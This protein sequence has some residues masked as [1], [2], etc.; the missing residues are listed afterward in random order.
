MKQQRKLDA[1]THRTEQWST[2]NRKL[3]ELRKQLEDLRL[4]LVAVRNYDA[5]MQDARNRLAH[6]NAQIVTLNRQ[7]SNENAAREERAQQR[8]TLQQRLEAECVQHA[9]A[10]KAVNEIEAALNVAVA[11]C[12][13][14]PIVDAS[15][16]NKCPIC[17]QALNEEHLKAII[18]ECTRREAEKERLQQEL[19][20][21]ISKKQTHEDA[22]AQLECKL[23]NLPEIDEDAEL[24]AKLQEAVKASDVASYEIDGLEAAGRPA[25]PIPQEVAAIEDSVLELSTILTEMEMAE[26]TAMRTRSEGE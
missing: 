11:H 4:A 21:A 26:A 20:A 3:K 23:S 9:E 14:W 2:V 5:D 8:K 22:I 17:N 18:D 25:T 16:G 10:E 1:L 7:I 24:H 19:Q 12:Q 15:Q 6:A 13:D